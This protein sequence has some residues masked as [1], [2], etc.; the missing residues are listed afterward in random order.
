MLVFKIANR[1]QL[2]DDLNKSKDN[3]VVE[4]SFRGMTAPMGVAAYELDK[5]VEDSIRKE[6]PT[7]EDIEK[8]LEGGDYE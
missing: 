4:W 8:A 5:V 7:I 6:L 2:V 3:T 1:Q